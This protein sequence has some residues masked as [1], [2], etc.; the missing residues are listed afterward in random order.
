MHVGVHRRNGTEREFLYSLYDIWSPTAR[1]TGREAAG[2][3]VGFRITDLHSVVRSSSVGFRSCFSYCFCYR[4]VPLIRRA[5]IIY[6]SI[7]VCCEVLGSGWCVN[8]D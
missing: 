8:E 7:Y 5:K 2:A 3:T 4:T 1:Q 6:N